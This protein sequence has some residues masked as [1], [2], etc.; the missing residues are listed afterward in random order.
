MAVGRC[1]IPDGRIEPRHGIRGKSQFYPAMKA[2]NYEFAG[3]D[4]VSWGVDSE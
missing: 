4:A 1:A 3:D 2:E